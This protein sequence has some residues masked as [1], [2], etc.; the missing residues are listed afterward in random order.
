MKEHKRTM[1]RA[2]YSADAVVKSG[3][4]GAVRGRLRDIA[5]DAM[6]LYINPIFDIDEQ[7]KVE[8]ILFGA[9]SQLIINVPAVVA[10]KDQ[11]GL[12]MRFLNPLEW[13]PIFSCFPLHS[14]DSGTVH[15]KKKDTRFRIISEPS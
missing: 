10:R 4:R 6:Y 8:I 14:L 7:V 11:N 9:D 5:I 3:K 1:T 12:A 13:W 15:H 2:D